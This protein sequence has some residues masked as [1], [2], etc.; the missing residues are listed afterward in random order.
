MV[1]KDRADW[2]EKVLGVNLSGLGEGGEAEEEEEQVDVKAEMEELKSLG[3]D[4]P[5]LWE[6]AVEAFNAATETVNGQIA[7]LQA[8]L[9]ETDDA[10]LHDIAEFGLGALTENTRVPL[11]AA[12]MEGGKG[13]PAQLKKA[14]PK[15]IKA[16]GAFRDRLK[17]EEV[18]ACDANPWVPTS[19]ALTFSEALGQIER[20]AKMAA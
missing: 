10:D 3:L 12:I 17:S 7:E 15:L 6:G 13:S 2:I 5:A 18:R 16:V 19:I 11:M 8:A 1:S 20:A 9:R 4:L 14:A